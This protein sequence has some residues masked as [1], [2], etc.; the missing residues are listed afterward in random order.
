MLLH[1]RAGHEQPLPQGP[2]RAGVQF[3]QTQRHVVDPRTRQSED[4]VRGDRLHAQTRRRQPPTERSR[5]ALFGLAKAD[6]YILGGRS[7][8]SA[9]SLG[10]SAGTSAT[11]SE[12]VTSIS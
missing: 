9:A 11:R 8:S 6:K 7:D 5:D 12:R 1:V 10:V 3:V 4:A 2:R